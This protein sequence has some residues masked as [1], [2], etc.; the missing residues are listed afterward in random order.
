[1]HRVLPVQLAMIRAISVKREE[2]LIRVSKRDGF[3]TSEELVFLGACHQLF[4][5]LDEY[6]RITADFAYGRS[7]D[8]AKPGVDSAYVEL[9]SSLASVP[10]Y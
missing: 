4:L 8:G 10:R 7:V 2:L 9:I 1:M 3:L 5:K 6:N